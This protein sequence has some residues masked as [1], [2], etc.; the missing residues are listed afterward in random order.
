[1]GCGGGRRGYLVLPKKPWRR[2]PDKHMRKG[3]ALSAM[4]S[5]R[6]ADTYTDRQAS[7]KAIAVREVAVGMFC[8]AHRSSYCCSCHSASLIFRVIFSEQPSK[9]LSCYSGRHVH[10]PGS[11]S[12]G[13][14]FLVQYDVLIVH[15]RSIPTARV[16]HRE[17]ERRDRR[18]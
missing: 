17:N 3:T 15:R 11:Q 13:T 12:R 1:M 4:I 6:Y 16:D 9:R 2:S 10:Q 5:G 18:R 14:R 8:G 7:L